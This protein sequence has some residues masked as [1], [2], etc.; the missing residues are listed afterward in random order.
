LLMVKY[1]YSGSVF[2]CAM[3]P[4]VLL[5]LLGYGLPAPAQQYQE[6]YRLQYH[7]SPLANWLNDPCGMVYLDGEYHL[8]Y[9]YNPF[10]TQWGNMSWGHAVSTDMVHWQELGVALRPDNLG[11]IFSGGVVIDHHNTAGFGAGAMVAIYTSASADQKQSIAY[12]LDKG[13]SWQKYSGNPVLPNQGIVDFRDPMVFW[14][15]ETDRWIMALAVL[16]RIE[17]YSS[18]NLKEWSFESDF[19]RGIGAQGGVWECPDL[20]KLRI[21]GTEEYQWVLMVSLN[22]GSPSGG[23]GTQYFL[24]HFD[25][26]AFTLSEE[27]SSLLGNELQ[28]PEGL[29]FD[30]FEGASYASHWEVVGEAFGSAPAEGT[31]PDQQVVSGYLG[32]QLVNSYRGGDAS[33]GKMTSAPFTIAHTHINFLIGGGNHPGRAEI[34]LL[35]E[36]EPVASATGRNEERLRWTSWEVGQYLGR[37]ARLE[38]VDSVQG[39]WGHINIDHVYFANQAVIDDRPEAL[40]ADWGPDFYA[41]R[42]WENQPQD[43]YQRVWLAWMNNWSYAGNLPTSGWRGSMSLPRALHL[44]QDVQG[45]TRLYQYPIEELEQL[46]RRHVHIEEALGVAPLNQ[47]LTARGVAGSRYELHFTL[48]P[49]EADRAG[50]E[51][52]KSSALKTT[53]GYDRARNAVFLDR[54]LSGRSFS[55]TYDKVF[56]APLERE[57]EELDF[58][59]FVDESS[60]E[61]FVNG[62]EAVITA[63]IFPAA[64]AQGIAFFGP[65]D[66]LIRQLD[67]WEFDTIW[68]A[69]EGV[70]GVEDAAYARGVHLY[71][72]PAAGGRVTLSSLAPIQSVAAFD[73]TGRQIPLRIK[74]DAEL[75]MVD[76]PDA[77]SA[78]LLLVRIQ[79]QSGQVVV[80]KVVLNAR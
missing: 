20:F 78:G 50:V 33:Q 51:V 31:L 35:V 45:R 41:G 80:K 75:L 27:F 42:S 76:F 19:G 40:W 59:I 11:A 62:G 30:D 60:V 38:I 65:A 2:K 6:P 36:G 21:D 29:L 22:P 57:Y 70:L 68:P 39:G 3:L 61:V 49:G 17:F 34:R 64:I 12:S 32:R 52:R 55:G 25:G 46:R 37:S 73:G 24:G 74:K 67:F 1:L 8:M 47:Q 48:R 77:P 14:H 63:R 4:A 54:S 58:R 15:D 53:I 9:Q 56:Y 10:G 69:D 7:F 71:P 23:S 79:L 16:D 26:S 5:V 28:L 18:P 72:N 13:R 66:A 44:Q 43:T